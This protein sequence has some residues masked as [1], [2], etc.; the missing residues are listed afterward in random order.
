MKDEIKEKLL[1]EIED[2]LIWENRSY[3]ERDIKSVIEKT[4][5]LK[6]KEFINI[7][8]YLQDDVDALQINY[9][10]LDECKKIDVYELIQEIKQRIKE[11]EE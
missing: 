6:D 5:K 2:A 3:D 10:N 7:L 11:K 8:S 9:A 1:K 4:S